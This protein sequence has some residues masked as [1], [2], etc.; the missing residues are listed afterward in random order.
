MAKPAPQAKRSVAQPAPGNGGGS[1]EQPAIYLPLTQLT[2]RSARM[3]KLKLTVCA[4]WEDF[5]TYT[6]DGQERNG[7][8]FKCHL[9]DTIDP[10]SYCHAEFKK[11]KKD[12]TA[13]E[14]A[15]AKF[16]NGATLVFSKIAFHDSAKTAYLS[17]PKREV[18]DLAKSTATQSLDSASNACAVQPCPTGSVA[19]NH[20]LKN[21]QRFDILALVKSV[22]DLRPAGPGRKV[23]EV[24]LLDGSR[25]PGNNKLKTMTVNMFTQEAQ[26]EAQ[27]AIAQQYMTQRVPVTFLQLAGAKDDE[28]KFSFQSA[29]K[30][31]FM[32][33]ANVHQPQS[34][35][36]Q[37]LK[38]QAETLLANE[39]TD[40]FDQKAFQKTDFT[41]LSAT[42]TS[43]N[44]FKSLPRCDSGIPS[45]DCQQSLW[46]I[47]WLRVHEPALGQT[48]WN[49][50][51]QKLWF[52]ISFRD[53]TDQHSLYIT[54]EAALK[55]SGCVSVQE[56]VAAHDAGTLWFPLVSS[57]KIVRR[58]NTDTFQFDAVI[59]D[60]GDQNLKEPPTVASLPLVNMLAARMEDGNVF[61]P[62][63]LNMIS[64]SVHY[65]MCVHY[66]KQELV[67]QLADESLDPVADTE[68]F[69]R[70]CHQVLA[71]VEASQASD[72]Q[73]I[74][75]DGFKLTTAGVRDLLAPE[76]TTL[77][78]LIAFC[79][80]KNVQDFQLAPPRGRKNQHALIII[81][82]VLDG[83]AEQP[84]KQFIVDSILQLRIDDV[85]EI[86][87]AV[88]KLMYYVAASSD[89]NKRKRKREWDEAFSPATAKICKSLTRHPTGE[90]LPG[91]STPKRS[92]A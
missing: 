60:A 29:Y 2:T 46:Q 66:A 84:E 38:Q 68:T 9:V 75:D 31:W 7:T 13:Y 19:Q 49:K 14:A 24:C 74:A 80:I 22:S 48:L 23:F 27:Q 16:Q 55:L 52:L 88:R 85:Q 82:D 42:E 78:T 44:L 91:Y 1:A 53:A 92:A 4:T 63:A 11:T 83:S 73:K 10:R 5:Y 90:P 54:E 35:K 40:G 71:L 8:T 56:F 81:S 87:E 77:Y 30:G 18:I 72:M 69:M 57:V 51:G 62:A 67:A 25:D 33:E 36:A 64:K 3:A 89:I 15:K 47:N 45:L 21:N 65:A 20:A 43:V 50:S 86:A 37:Y 79:T 41:L 6:W 17:A 12:E 32:L 58:R 34:E 76:D 28:G 70:P 61:L 39:E 59:V 26:A